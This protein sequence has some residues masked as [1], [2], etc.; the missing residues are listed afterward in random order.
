MKMKDLIGIVAE[1]PYRHVVTWDGAQG[2]ALWSIS[3]GTRKMA[4]AKVAFDEAKRI[5]REGGDGTSGVLAV[6][7]KVREILPEAEHV[8][9]IARRQEGISV[10]FRFCVGLRWVESPSG[11]EIISRAY[12]TA[13]LFGRRR[14]EGL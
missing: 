13:E 1:L 9:V 11:L 8:E 6:L 14:P 7:R 10:A 3:S 5:P 4:N 12:E 2:I